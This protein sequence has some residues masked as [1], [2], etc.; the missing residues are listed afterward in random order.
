MTTPRLLI[1]GRLRKAH[2]IRGDLVVEPI[3]DAPDAV[4]AAGARLFVGTA[5]GDPAPEGWQLTVR[6]VRTL[7]DGWLLLGFVEVA[8]R[9]DAER[10]RGRY[11]LAP[12]SALRPPEPGEVYVHDLFGMHVELPTGESL[13]DVSDVFELPQGIALEIELEGRRALLPFREEFV[14]EVDAAARR[15]VVTPPEGL[16]E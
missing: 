5:T 9:N 11:L 6:H 2:G 13:G 1:V 16:F 7:G 15:L 4:F 3:T 10:W 12:D 8:D 14:R